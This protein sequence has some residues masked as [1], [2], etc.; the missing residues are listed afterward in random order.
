MLINLVLAAINTCNAIE[1]K[2]ISDYLE[3]HCV[4]LPEADQY[5]RR[6]RSGH[7]RLQ[8]IIDCVIKFGTRAERKLMVKAQ[9]EAFSHNR[10][11]AS[12]GVK[13][14]FMKHKDSFKLWMPMVNAFRKALG[15]LLNG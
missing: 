7:V 4:H 14:A 9:R 6:L 15:E 5:I 8:T 13:R 1:P 11:N 12:K 3:D 2:I 10:W